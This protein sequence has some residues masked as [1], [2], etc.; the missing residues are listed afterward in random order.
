MS[1]KIENLLNLSLTST[2]DERQKAINLAIG[3]DDRNNTWEVLVKYHGSIS[4]L[5]SQSIRVEELINGY[6]IVTLPATSIEALAALEEIEYIEMPKALYF[7]IINARRGSCITQVTD[8]DP[9]LTGRGVLVAVIDS[10]IDYVNQNF[11]NANGETRIMSLWDQTLIPDESKGWFSP[12]GFSIGVEFSE[13]QINEALA[14]GQL[15]EIRERV[16]SFDVSGHGTA[17][18]GIATANGEDGM[19][20]YYGIAPEAGLLVVKMGNPGGVGFPRTTEMMRAVVYALRKSIEFQMPLVINISFG[21]SYGSHEGNSLLERFLDNASEIGRTAIVIAAGNEGAAA[22]HYTGAVNTNETQRIEL[23]VAEYERSLSIQLWKNY[24]DE[25]NIELVAPDGTRARIL[26]TQTG[27][28]R[29]RLMNTELLIYAGE[30]LPYMMNQEVY[31]SLIPVGEYVDSGVWA[32]EVL[33]ER[34]V[35]GE[36]DLYL[37]SQAVLNE[38]TG[39]YRP[40]PERTL[41]IPSTSYKT[42]AV[43]AYDLIFDAYAPFSGRGFVYRN[44]GNNRLQYPN[45]KP[46]IVA[47][48]VNLTAVSVDGGYI[49]V[50]GTSFAAPVVSGSAALMMEWGIVRGNDAFLYGEKLKAYLIRGARQL[51]GMQNPNAMTGWGALCLQNSLP[52]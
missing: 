41:T 22:G 39:F 51:P 13:T 30:P 50:S 12:E 33:G 10:G 29:L 16:P 9:F 20:T 27:T 46:E 47:P 2:P 5:N 31:F 52:L 19:Q 28:Q 36:F 23:S 38:A 48:G 8:R 44:E 6:A 4:N 37:P 17:V 21:N 42:I 49:T 18:A 1:Q 35:N 24:Q 25:I 11:R 3:Y 32:V 40:T 14:A 43:G 7:Q 26:S 45:V 15:Q 34:I